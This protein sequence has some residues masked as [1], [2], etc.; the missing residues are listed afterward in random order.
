[1]SFAS[2]KL[3]NGYLRTHMPT[4]V[5]KVKVREIVPHLPCLTD[6]DRET[7]EV[8]R[9]MCGNFDSMVLLLDCL[10]RRD[11]WL[12]HFIRAL[13]MCEHGAIAAEIQA[14][15]DKLQGASNSAPSSPPTSVVKVHVDPAPSAAHPSGSE[16]SSPSQAATFPSC[17]PQADPEPEIQTPVPAPP[18]VSEQPLASSASETDMDPLES[19]ESNKAVPEE[20]SFSCDASLE[21]D[22]AAELCDT[23]PCDVI[24]SPPKSPIDLEVTDAC[25]SPEKHLVQET[26]ATVEKLTPAAVTPEDILEAPATQIIVEN[27]SATGNLVDPVLSAAAASVCLSTLRTLT[28][29]PPQENPNSDNAGSGSSADPFSGD[30]DHLE[31]SEEDGVRVN[32][33]HISQQSS[34]LNSDGQSTVNGVATKEV[35]AEKLSPRGALPANGKFIATALGVGVCAL[36]VAWKFKH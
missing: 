10:K 30:T 33:V 8:K 27:C 4:I 2:D 21:S 16:I 34:V 7:I 23:A 9:E 11:S 14:E 12:E 20:V 22:Q 6:Q 36:L 18:P 15:Y 17:P 1:M 25:R 5:T 32:V 31:I 24:E 13:D 29:I 19:S 35:E 3:Y 28:S 26:A